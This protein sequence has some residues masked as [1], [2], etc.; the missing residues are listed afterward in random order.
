MWRINIH[1]NRKSESQGLTFLPADLKS[2]VGFD[3]P[4]C[5]YGDS[6]AICKS[7]EL[8]EPDAAWDVEDVS[9]NVDRAT[10]K[11]NYLMV[12]FK[13]APGKEQVQKVFDTEY[14]KVQLSAAPTVVAYIDV[15][16]LK[17]ALK[18]IQEESKGTPWEVN[19]SMSDIQDAADVPGLC[20]AC[21]DENGVS[22]AVDVFGFLVADP[23]GNDIRETQDAAEAK[24]LLQEYGTKYGG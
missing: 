21:Y 24:K 19:Y 11:D 18:A 7:D 16:P 15:K 22:I 23:A 14:K 6:L 17:D 8:V 9:L 1:E 13:D 12:A 5:Y 2:E 10:V 3:L 20:D 4:S